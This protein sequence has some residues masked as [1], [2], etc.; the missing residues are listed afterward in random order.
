MYYIQILK[1]I[2]M[3]KN[4]LMTVVSV[5]SCLFASCRHHGTVCFTFDLNMPLNRKCV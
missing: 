2:M 5:I 3:K 1:E 4:I